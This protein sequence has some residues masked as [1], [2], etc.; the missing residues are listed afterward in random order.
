MLRLLH[1][2][3]T[4]SIGTI[5]LMFAIGFLGLGLYM[6]PGLLGAPLNNL[7]A[8]LPPRQALR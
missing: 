2:E 3:A 8:W 5:R 7:D 4:E 1:G 6:F